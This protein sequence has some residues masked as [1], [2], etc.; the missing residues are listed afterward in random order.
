MKETRGV[1]ELRPAV[2]RKNR[3]KKERER[4]QTRRDAVS[5]HSQ[6][7]KLTSEAAWLQRCTSKSPQRTRWRSDQL[8]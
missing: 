4:D 7:I 8:R 6:G 3:G 5:E 1:L 2:R